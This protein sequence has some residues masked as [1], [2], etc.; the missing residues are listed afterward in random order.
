[1]VNNSLAIALYS[2]LGYQI[3]GTEK[4]SV[5]LRSGFVDE[6]VMAKLI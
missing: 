5:F 6:Y 3:E 2:K 1:M 4:N